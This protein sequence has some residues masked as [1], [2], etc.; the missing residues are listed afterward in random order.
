[1]RSGNLT[2]LVLAC[3]LLPV[4]CAPQ[5]E[6][7]NSLTDDRV[8]A[9]YPTSTQI[10][11]WTSGYKTWHLPPLGHSPKQSQMKQTQGSLEAVRSKNCEEYSFADE[12]IFKSPWYI[13]HMRSNSMESI[14]PFS[15]APYQLIVP[16]P[17]QALLKNQIPDFISTF[18]WLLVLLVLNLRFMK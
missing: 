3:V 13:P 8:D 17:A 15:R 1:M 12:E 9:D 16:K 7:R 10:E 11:A 6:G 5:E 14:R 4:L 2:L 18:E